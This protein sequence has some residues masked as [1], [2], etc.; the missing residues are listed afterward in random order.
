MEN[1]REASAQLPDVFWAKS[2]ASSCI[3]AS[4][5]LCLLFIISRRFLSTDR[6]AKVNDATPT[7]MIKAHEMFTFV[8]RLLGTSFMVGEKE[9]LQ[10]NQ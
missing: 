8:S 2:A 1:S 6:L 3:R 5:I 9:K 10:E 4:L 7:A